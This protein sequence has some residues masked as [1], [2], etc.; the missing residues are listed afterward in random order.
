MER[1]KLNKIMEYLGVLG[2]IMILIS[3]IIE[4]RMNTDSL[5]FLWVIGTVMLIGTSIY[6][7]VVEKNKEHPIPSKKTNIIVFCIIFITII[8]A[9]MFKDVVKTFDLM[10]IQTILFCFLGMILVGLVIYL[11]YENKKRIAEM[12]KE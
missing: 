12:P 1:K 10:S 2:A 7:L 9:M 8:M 3:N 6:L 11:S 5:S 4:I